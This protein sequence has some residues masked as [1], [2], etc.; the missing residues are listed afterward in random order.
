MQEENLEAETDEQVLEA[1][2]DF[3]TLI[4]NSHKEG[5]RQSSLYNIFGD[6]K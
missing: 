4:E 5:V 2:H 1:S 6:Y 3:L